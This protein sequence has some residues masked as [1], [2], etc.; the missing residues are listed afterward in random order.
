MLIWISREAVQRTARILRSGKSLEVHA[1]GRGT[2]NPEAYLCLHTAP[3]RPAPHAH[4]PDQLQRWQNTIDLPAYDVQAGKNLTALVT[5]RGLI[6][7]GHNQIPQFPENLDGYGWN[8]EVS[9]NN[10]ETGVPRGKISICAG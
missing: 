6:A 3:I 2:G 4:Q 5:C 9:R 7:E 10:F 8:V 1:C